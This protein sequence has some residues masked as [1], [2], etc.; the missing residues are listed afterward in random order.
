M[1]AAYLAVNQIVLNKRGSFGGIYVD[2]AGG[3][4]TKDN[5]DQIAP[6]AEKAIR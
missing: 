1:M 6:L 3:F 4:V 2:T 5:I